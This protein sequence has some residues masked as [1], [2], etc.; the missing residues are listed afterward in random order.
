MPNIAQTISQQ[1][2]LTESTALLCSNSSIQTF[3]IR[4]PRSLNI[5]SRTYQRW[6]HWRDCRSWTQYF[7][8]LSHVTDIHVHSFPFTNEEASLSLFAHHP[9][10]PYS[11]LVFKGLRTTSTFESTL[12]FP[13]V[14]QL[15]KY[16][17]CIRV[18]PTL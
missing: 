10:H 8:C 5:L 14:S 11:F 2:G 16:I 18:S 13:S 17:S 1:N 12:L 7:P 6:M 4:P 9:L 15:T 3:L